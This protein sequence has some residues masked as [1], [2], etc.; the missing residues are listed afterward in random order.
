MDNFPCCLFRLHHTLWMQSVCN[1]VV[2]L[3]ERVGE[4]Q[5]KSAQCSDCRSVD[6]TRHSLAL[7][8][9]NLPPPSTTSTMKALRTLTTAILLPLLTYSLPTGDSEQ[10]PF[11][12][13]SLKNGSDIRPLVLWHGLGASMSA[14]FANVRIFRTIINILSKFIDYRDSF[15][16]RME[17]KL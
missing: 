14:L 3:V 17:E 12:A 4:K 5:M 9:F 11:T 1:S 6:R 7:A 16:S 15:C 10:V 2:V 13:S 8:T